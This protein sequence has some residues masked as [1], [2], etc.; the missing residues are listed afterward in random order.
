MKPFNSTYVYVYKNL[1]TGGLEIADYG[2]R[3]TSMKGFWSVVQKTKI[4]SK[5]N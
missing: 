3:I 1:P 2:H 5:S 4:E